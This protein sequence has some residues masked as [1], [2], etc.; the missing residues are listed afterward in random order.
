VRKRDTNN[1]PQIGLTEKFTKQ[2][3][4]KNIEIF[5]QW[6][7]YFLLIASVRGAPP[8]AS[9]IL[10]YNDHFEYGFQKPEY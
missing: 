8:Q 9:L 4:M 3:L 10:L 6:G 7:R 2:K 1:I 5:L